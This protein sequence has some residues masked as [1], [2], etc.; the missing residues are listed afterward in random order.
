MWVRQDGINLSNSPSP[1]HPSPLAHPVGGASNIITVIVQRKWPTFSGITDNKWLPCSALPAIKWHHID[2]EYASKVTAK[3]F[4]SLLF[5]SLLHFTLAAICFSFCFS[6]DCFWQ[7]IVHIKFPE[8]GKFWRQVGL[9]DQ[10]YRKENTINKIQVNS[11]LPFHVHRISAETIHRKIFKQY[12]GCYPLKQRRLCLV[13][14]VSKPCL[15][16]TD[17]NTP[18]TNTAG[19]TGLV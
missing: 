10:Y 8:Y 6:T 7:C 4:M 3:C 9:P 16:L 1:S 18:A 14:S 5:I 2:G 19:L 11:S 13:L 15:W 17:S 12:F